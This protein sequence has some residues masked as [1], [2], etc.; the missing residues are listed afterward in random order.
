VRLLVDWGGTL[1]VAVGIV[2]VVRACVV[3]PYRVP[4]AVMEP[5]LHCEREAGAGVA[6]ARGCTGEAADRVLV[7]RVTY[8]LR[9]PQRKDIVAVEVSPA[10]ARQCGLEEGEVVLLRVLG[11]PG[12]TLTFTRGRLAVDGERVQEPYVEPKRRGRESGTWR[13]ARERWFLLGDNRVDSCDSRRWGGVPSSS[14][15]GAVFARYWPSE[16]IG[17]AAALGR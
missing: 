10:A 8:R 17:L 1:L 15:Q 11:L 2:L 4:S 13:V 9:D 7:N 16:R 5:T 12:E 14:L 3:T 6:A